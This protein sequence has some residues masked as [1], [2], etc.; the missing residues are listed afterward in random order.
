[1]A[2]ST[3]LPEHTLSPKEATSSCT[4]MMGLSEL[5]GD[6]ILR[7]RPS[8]RSIPSLGPSTTTPQKKARRVT[9]GPDEAALGRGSQSSPVLSGITLRGD[10]LIAIVDVAAGVVGRNMKKYSGQSTSNTG[11]VHF[12]GFQSSRDRDSK[13]VFAVSKF[14]VAHFETVGLWLCGTPITSPQIPGPQHAC[15]ALKTDEDK[16]KFENDCLPKRHRNEL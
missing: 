5:K 14:G 8:D 15:H 9:V 11:H 4:S 12:S 7:N 6:S 16:W 2:S 13:L 3:L 10:V 1:M